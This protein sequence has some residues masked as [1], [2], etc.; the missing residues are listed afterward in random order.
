MGMDLPRQKGKGL[1]I[2]RIT[3]YDPLAGGLRLSPQPLRLCVELIPAGKPGNPGPRC[4]R[5]SS[6]GRSP[7]FTAGFVV[8]IFV[9]VESPVLRPPIEGREFPPILLI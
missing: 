8:K 7:P 5:K 2:Y 4:R 3:R 9:M 1:E 6:S